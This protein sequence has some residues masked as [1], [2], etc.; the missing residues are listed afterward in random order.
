MSH[1]TH[2]L[3]GTHMNG[4]IRP[5]EIEVVIHTDYIIQSPV[6]LKEIKQLLRYHSVN[7]LVGVEQSL[8]MPWEV[9]GIKF[10]IFVSD[11]FSLHNEVIDQVWQLV[12]EHISTKENA[13]V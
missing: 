11:T 5:E 4:I 13:N 12:E 1:Y 2:Q 6:L 7:G 3:S 9:H 10:S 8:L